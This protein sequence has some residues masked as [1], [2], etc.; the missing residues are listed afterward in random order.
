[1]AVTLNAIVV[2]EDHYC[3]T[4]PDHLC[5]INFGPIRR[6]R[7]N[8][9]SSQQTARGIQAQNPHRSRY[10]VHSQLEPDRL[11]HLQTQLQRLILGYDDSTTPFSEQRHGSSSRR[12]Y[13]T[14]P[15]SYQRHGVNKRDDAPTLF[16]DLC[17]DDGRS[18][19]AKTP[20]GNMR[21]SG[22]KCDDTT[23]HF[24][25]PRQRSSRHDDAATHLCVM[26]H[27]NG[28]S[29]DATRTVSNNSRIIESVASDVVFFENSGISAQDVIIN[30]PFL[31][32]QSSGA[33][34]PCKFNL[35]TKGA[36]FFILKSSSEDEIRHSIAD[37]AWNGTS[38]DG[39]SRLNL[40]IYERQGRGPVI[41]FF[42]ISGSGCFCGVAQMTSAVD[43][44]DDVSCRHQG[45]KKRGKFK[46]RWIYAKN[47]PN[48]RFC[49]IRLNG[50]ES[51]TITCCLD[52]E[53]VPP[54]KGKQILNIVHAFRHTSS[55]LHEPQVHNVKLLYLF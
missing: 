3:G 21:H 36:R 13:A 8:F 42:N 7:A 31:N 25:D 50:A 18:V 45:S 6:R 10:T 32:K 33:L 22:S 19:D 41:L 9:G 37:S 47:V 11:L 16:G 39:N 52:T 20:F 30:N 29:N 49:H 28:R 26:C 38:E 23:T 1:M 46:V 2:P 51:K 55:V 17:H 27:G 44:R 5:E 53:E 54:N 15:F 43:Y 35:S 14:A 12:E 34:N 4:E 40:A 24:N 48:D